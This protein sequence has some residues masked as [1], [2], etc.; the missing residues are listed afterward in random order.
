MTKSVIRTSN[1]LKD[2]LFDELDNY[3][4]GTSTVARVNAVAKLT[5]SIVHVAKLELQHSLSKTQ[6]VTI[7]DNLKLGS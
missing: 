3:R 6:G 7:S 5:N 2:I 4:E 1:G